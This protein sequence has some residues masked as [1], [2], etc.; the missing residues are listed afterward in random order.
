MNSYIEILRLPNVLM[1]MIAVILMAIVDHVY[2]WNIIL[3]A[4]CVFISTG[5]GNTINDYY[6][7]EIDKINKPNRPIPSG[8][9]D[10]K[11]ALYYSIILFIISIIIGFYISTQAGIVVLLC[12]L[13]EIL[14]A[15]DLKKR[16]LIGNIAVS[17]LTGLT[18]IFGGL[19]TNDVLTGSLLGL[20]ALLMTLSREIIKDCED[21]EGDKMEGANT[22]AIAYGKDTAIK[23][24][25]IINIITC[26]LSPVLYIIG[27]FSI[28]YMIIVLVADIIFIYSAISVLRN[29]SSSNLGRASGNMKIG[30]FIAFISFA[31]GSII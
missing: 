17:L 22:Y 24:A 16:V 15:K 12:A 1:A 19:I 3:G 23:T 21:I 4:I 6:D 10:R 20:F 27:L 31:I 25:V 8:Q 14:Y 30:M 26:L 29:D 28:Y 11:T 13:L 5:S 2:T 18:F 9:I 7:Y